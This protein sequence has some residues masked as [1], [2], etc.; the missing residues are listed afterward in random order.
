LS[1]AYSDQELHR[2]EKKSLLPSS[3][4]AARFALYASFALVMPDNVE[5]L[6]G[7]QPGEDPDPLT[8][9]IAS[10]NLGQ[11]HFLSY[12]QIEIEHETH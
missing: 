5:P 10:G 12:F 1:L 2:G 4:D 8:L 6:K 9:E 7:A 11:G 3:A